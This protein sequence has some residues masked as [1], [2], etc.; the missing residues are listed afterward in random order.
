MS[1]LMSFVR[2]FAEGGGDILAERARQKREDDIRKQ[3]IVDEMN[4]YSDK[5]QVDFEFS[6]KELDIAKDKRKNGLIGLGFTEEYLD[7]F[8]QYALESD[9]NA[10]LWLQM[11]EKYYGTPFWHTTPI[12]YHRDKSLVGKTIQE[13]QLGMANTNDNFDNKQV[14]NN[15][16]KENNLTD[17][18]ADSQFTDTNISGNS[19]SKEG[20]FSSPNFV[21]AELFFGKKQYKTGDPKTFIGEDGVKVTAFRVSQTPGEDDYGS[22][23]Y[24]HTKNGHMPIDSFYGNTAYFDIGSDIG[25]NMANK[26]Y[27]TIES[28]TPVRYHMSVGG[29]TYILHGTHTETTDGRLTKEFNYVPYNFLQKFPQFNTA[30]F[31]ESIPGVEGAPDAPGAGFM[32]QEDMQYYTI[33]VDKFRNALSTNGI[34]FTLNQFDDQAGLQLAETIGGVKQPKEFSLVDKNRSITSDLIPATGLDFSQS[35]LTVNEY[36]GEIDTNLFSGENDQQF[37]AKIISSIANNL[38]QSWRDNSISN[39]LSTQLGFNNEALNANDASLSL[40][41]SKLGITINT[42][43]NNIRSYYQD[44]IMNYSKEDF[45]SWRN[46]NDIAE[47]EVEQNK[48][49]IDMFAFGELKEANTIEELLSLNSIINQARAQEFEQAEASAFSSLPGAEGNVQTGMDVI[50]G[51]I[52]N[53]MSKDISDTELLTKEITELVGGDANKASLIINSDFV[54]NQIANLDPDTLPD[55]PIKE[56]EEREET[57]TKQ[58]EALDVEDWLKEGSVD[59]IPKIPSEAAEWKKTNASDP[60]VKN[61][62]GG[63]GSLYDK[64][65]GFQLFKS[66]DLPPGHVEPRPGGDNPNAKAG[67]GDKITQNWDLLYSKTHNADGTPKT[68][69]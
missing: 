26:F 18:I 1:A 59:P 7:A 68:Q 17:N 54:V 65:T 44:L 41:G 48:K 23:Y 37:N 57:R 45:E 50:T 21:G 15:T 14:V 3:N 29:D 51:I 8:G 67:R 6:Q 36:T 32:T 28:E 9:E 24:V 60:N 64:D 49:S 2:G 47:G 39:E 69:E 33:D 46:A 63:Q 55:T 27:P 16:K 12:N 42:V 13:I 43:Q 4:L 58:I 30:E 19:V 61:M 34:N 53:T 22:I 62:A 31:F 40:I 66:R 5:K 56:V 20:G 38:L 10:Q 25:K 35:Q 11:N 52:K